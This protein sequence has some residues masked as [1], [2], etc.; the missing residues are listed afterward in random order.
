MQPTALIA[1]GGNALIRTDEPASAGGERVHVAEVCRAIGGIVA[2]GWN[3]VITHGNGPQVGAALLR[4]ERAAD[5]AYSLPLDVCVASTQ[6]EL[7]YLL[8]QTLGADLQARN[9]SRPI[10]AIVTQVVVD[11]RDRAFAR[12]TKPI[13]PFY[14]AAEAVSRRKCGWTL[15]EERPHGWRRVVP[16]P[17]P[18]EILE[19]PIVRALIEANAVVIALGGGGIPVV[20][21]AG[22]VAGIEAVVDKDLASALLATRLAVD[23]F[24]LA[25]DVD[26][27]YLDFGTAHARALDEIAA[28]DLRRHAAAG[29]FPEG[30][31]GPKVEAAL[32]FV[33]RV[34]HDALVCSHNELQSALAGGAGTRIVGRHSRGKP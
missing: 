4:S 26:H 1:I 12:P 23:R 20:R 30:S 7:G 21:H 13:G 2:G 6:G 14:S 15:V 5:E 29:Q 24:V 8:Q 11:E 16:S 32:R 3:V 10:A 31:M 27:I 17:E 22:L 18:L 34:G 28:C 19:E 9:V 25:T 33:E